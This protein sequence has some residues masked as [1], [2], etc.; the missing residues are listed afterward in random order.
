MRTLYI[1]TII[2]GLISFSCSCYK[3]VAK[4][5]SSQRTDV[6]TIETNPD[7]T[8]IWTNQ[9]NSNSTKIK[10]LN[11]AFTFGSLPNGL[12]KMGYTIIENNGTYLVTNTTRALSD[13]VRVRAW[14][15]G[16]DII[17]TSEVQQYKETE[18]GLPQPSGFVKCVRGASTS[19]PDCWRTILVIANNLGGDKRYQ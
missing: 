18:F 9:P 4:D 13:D 5:T 15:E 2:L 12:K 10:V 17:L 11:A 7:Q 16:Q 14:V 19:L 1:I 6:S 3:N 8:S